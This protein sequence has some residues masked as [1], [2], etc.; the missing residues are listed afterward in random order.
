MIVDANMHWLPADLF[1]DEAPRDSFVSCVPNSDDWSYPVRR[2]WFVKGIDF[3]R[4][5]D[6]PEDS[7][8]L[9]LSGNAARLFKIGG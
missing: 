2:E 5:L 8:A 9:I 1:T 6:I 4:S 3:V 7:K